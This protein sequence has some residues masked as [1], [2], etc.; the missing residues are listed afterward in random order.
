MLDVGC[1]R[2]IVGRRISAK[3]FKMGQHP[4]SDIQHPS[5]NPSVSEGTEA[6]P[7]AEPNPPETELR[8]EPTDITNKEVA[9]Q[10]FEPESRSTE[11][12]LPED[13]GPVSDVEFDHHRA[14]RNPKSDISW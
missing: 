9:A 12:Q 4:T 1:C 5:Y 2:F 3:G 6:E 7:K 14:L 11:P 10:P 8:N 13:P